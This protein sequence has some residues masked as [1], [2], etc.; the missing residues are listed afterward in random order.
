V[1]RSIRLRNFRRYVDAT[2]DLSEGLNFIEGVNNAGK[3]TVLY[4]I[5]YA[6]F[7][8]VG[9][10]LQ[11]VSL[12]H[13]GSKQVGVELVFDGKDGRTYRLQRM[14]EKPPRSR[15]KVVG[16]F[17]LKAA[18]PDEEGEKYLLSSDFDDREA[19]LAVA[20]QEALGLTKRAYDLAVHLKQGEIPA[21]LDGS[22]QLD[23]VL[24]VTASVFVE[25][26]L[27]AMALER[28]KA[29]KTLPVLVATLE[30]LD[31]ER[32]D[33]VARQDALA[34]EAD[35][36]QAKA[37]AHAVR[38][39]ELDAKRAARAPL[40]AATSALRDALAARDDAK[41]ALTRATDAADAAGSVE[42]TTA[43]LTRA[44]DA[45]TAA[46]TARDAAQAT[47]DDL[48][49]QAE[50]RAADKGDLSGRLARRQAAS[51]G[52]TCDHCGQEVDAAH[53]S[54]EIPA[55]EAALTDLDGSI[56]A[57]QAD[58]EAARTTLRT[59]TDGVAEAQVA[60][61]AAE[62][63]V[64]RSTDA[65]AAA[66]TA[67]AARADADAALNA[68]TDA[69]HAF[70]DSAATDAALLAAMDEAVQAARDAI[71]D[72]EIRIE[73]ETAHLREQQA[74]VATDQRDCAS[75]LAGIDR[76]RAATASEADALRAD[77]ELGAKLRSLS[78][79]FKAV[80][81]DL[82]EQA[83][84]SMATRS[85]ELHRHL[86]GDDK[87]LKDLSIDSKRYTVEV[88]PTDVGSKVPAALYQ[89]GGH[90]LLLGL[91]AR[92]ALAEQLGPVPFVLLD[93]PTYGLDRD[94]RKALLD[95]ISS[96]DV[97]K[98]LLLITHHD[99]ADAGGRRIQVTREGKTSR[100]QGATP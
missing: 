61:S 55:L 1:I 97:A 46:T 13:P 98:Q 9:T 72:E 53:L 48:Q 83:T 15:T 60:R 89:G 92:L 45:V 11:A 4:A 51:E 80:Q 93:E 68:A 20:V 8:K 37:D 82:R 26:E 50:A 29:A 57:L 76:D 22:P 95:R 96:L 75:S 34:S 10:N 7:G 77:A 85:L 65:A 99:A 71:R 2:F 14:H 25:E 16:H 12:M 47:L 3:T 94:R 35:A 6:L 67:K 28:E 73:T 84:A 87:E 19:Q 64:A 31:A 44:S 56:A 27:R 41:A 70:V 40:I 52:G 66:D 81:Q 36:L 42:D 88:T 74:R 21:I 78:K 38:E 5:E 18:T 59:A 69:A 49:R 58:T 33:K 30:R 90:R 24:G 17:T 32:A 54:R 43:A 63:A 23:I 39:E 100:A 86:S 79:A 62:A 91:A